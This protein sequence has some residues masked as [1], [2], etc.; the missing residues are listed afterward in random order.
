MPRCVKVHGGRV[1]VNNMMRLKNSRNIRTA[2]R[3]SMY[4]SGMQT[5]TNLNKLKNSLKTISLVSKKPKYISF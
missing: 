3:L 1:R 5:E 2:G 4:G